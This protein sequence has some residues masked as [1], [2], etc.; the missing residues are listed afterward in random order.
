LDIIVNAIGI[1]Y[2]VILILSAFVRNRAID[3]MRV[4]SLFLPEPTEKTRPVN[5]VIGIMV[6]GYGI[7]S[8]LS[9]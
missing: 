2:G 4:D 7:Y 5:I 3:A 8:L 1:I 9:R 6:A